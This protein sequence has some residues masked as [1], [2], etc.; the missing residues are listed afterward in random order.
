[1]NISKNVEKL[2]NSAV[3]LTVTVPAAE[4]DKAYNNLLQK[5]AKEVQIKGFRKGKVPR[6]ILELKFGD[7]LKQETA[8][9]LIDEAF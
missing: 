4:G 2:D 5:Y 7:G 6:N 9:N 1:M 8:G 3:K